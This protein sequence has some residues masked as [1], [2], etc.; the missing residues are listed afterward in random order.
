MPARG[1]AIYNR[2]SD[3]SYCSLP[4]SPQLL[5]RVPGFVSCPYLCPVQPCAVYQL[6]LG[7]DPPGTCLVIHWVK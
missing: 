1:V 2:Q 6:Y 5:P 7:R 4:R 3:P